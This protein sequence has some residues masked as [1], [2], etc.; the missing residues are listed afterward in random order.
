MVNK[1]TVILHAFKFVSTTK[2]YINILLN[3][4]SDSLIL[5][6]MIEWMMSSCPVSNMSL[7]M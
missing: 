6:F 3:F 5:K 4:Y 1:C 2:T 7:K